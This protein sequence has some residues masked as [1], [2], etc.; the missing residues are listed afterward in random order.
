V[1]DTDIP[2]S[3]LGALDTLYQT[4]LSSVVADIAA[5][6]IQSNAHTILGAIM[7]FSRLG[8]ANELT[9]PILITLLAHLNVTHAKSFLDELRSIMITDDDNKHGIQL[10]HKLLNNFL[11]DERRCGRRNQHIDISLPSGKP[12]AVMYALLSLACHVK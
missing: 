7:V 10:M 1:L 4:V 8:N 11:M 12:G 3:S 6:D 5:E 2:S 9:T